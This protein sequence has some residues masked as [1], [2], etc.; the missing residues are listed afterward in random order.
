MFTNHI[1]PVLMNHSVLSASNLFRYANSLDGSRVR[2]D[3]GSRSLAMLV[4]GDNISHNQIK[5]I[6]DEASRH[7]KLKIRR[8]YGDWTKPNLAQWKEA[9]NLN[10]I[11]QVQQS[12]YTKGKNSTDGALIIDAMRM[13]YEKKVDGFCIVSSDGDYTGLAIEL[14]E[15]GKF[16]L[17]IG[18]KETPESLVNACD[19]FTHIETITAKGS[20]RNTE[21]VEFVTEAIGRDD[22]S[23]VLLTDVGQRLRAVNR[24]FD[25]RVYGFQ[26]LSLLVRSRP[27]KFILEN[28]EIIGKISGHK[29]RLKMDEPN[30]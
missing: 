9:A 3:E 17:G 1:Q 15:Q 16:V 19:Q 29:V 30:K 6:I 2:M 13:L 23:W 4:D 7:G 25:P 20:K 26:S 28:H 11:R 14:H 22:D 24:A 5:T 21:W 27:D 18:N 10:A 8:V 12:N